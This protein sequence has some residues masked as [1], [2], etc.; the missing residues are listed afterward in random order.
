MD[1]R[2]INNPDRLSL[3]YAAGITEFIDIAKQFV[4]SKGNVLCP[5]CRCVNKQSQSMRVIKLHLITH[6]FLCTYTK[7]YHHGEQLEEVQNKELFDSEEVDNENDNLAGGLHDAIGG[8]YFDIGPTSD[9]TNTKF[10][11]NGGDNE[12]RKLLE[13]RGLSELEV[14][15]HQKEEFLSWFKTK[16]SQMRVRKSPLVNDDLYSISQGPLERYNSYQSCIVNGVRFRCKK[17]DDTL[18]TQC[19]GVCTEGDHDDEY[20]TYYGILIEILQLSFL[21]D[22]K[23]PPFRPTE[24]LV[25]SSSLV[26]QDVAPLAL[27]DELVSEL[28]IKNHN[29][30]M[31]DQ[32]DEDFDDGTIFFN[33]DV[34]LSSDDELFCS[35]DDDILEMEFDNRPITE[36]TA[37]I[38]PPECTAHSTGHSQDDSVASQTQSGQS[39]SVN[40]SRGL[41]RGVKTASIA[42]ASANG[43][44]PVTFDEEC[45]QPI[46]TN[47]ERF[48]NDIG[49]IVRNHGS[50]HYKEWRVVPEEIRAP[51]R[52]YLLE[53]YDIDLL[54]ETTIKCI[55][56]QMRKAWRSHKYKLHTYFKEIGGEEDVEMAKRKRHPDLKDDHQEDWEILCDRWC[57]P[58]FKER[59]LKNT[60][61]RSKRKWESRNGSVSTPR[62]HIRRGMDLASSTGQ[63]ETWR[64]KHYDMEKGWT[65]PDL[66]TLYN[67][68]KALRDQH[69]PEEL[70]DKNIMER[71]L[72]RRSVHLRG[73]GRS[74]NGAS[75]T[76][77]RNTTQPDHPTYEELLQKLNEAYNRLDST[78]ERLSLVVDILHHNNLMPPPNVPPSDQASGARNRDSSE[79][80]EQQYD[81]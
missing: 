78:N 36:S 21:F 65:G 13:Q 79:I 61:N 5:C 34:V 52:H 1:R 22:R 72:G 60:N 7:W 40:K 73:W 24:D 63:I 2:W 44:L 45:R 64:L 53:T 16:I 69:T 67:E 42:K 50:F 20:I 26:R 48:N 15:N 33:N 35:S 25:E 4:D 80:Q 74:F 31:E 76:S 41:T 47:A 32:H 70:S 59:A 54:D 55:D 77:Q 9:F 23:L 38:Q 6:G 12:H 56:E 58:E 68:M 19:S 14:A 8:E 37:H 43:K 46:C 66:E 17:R 57:T 49:F 27:A 10:Q 51:L 30:S 62:H 28:N 3:E 29:Q 81:S 11:H 75:G 39:V 71:I 18:Q